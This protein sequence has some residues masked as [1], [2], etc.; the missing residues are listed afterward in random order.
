MMSF[1]S[2]IKQGFNTW[3]ASFRSS[4]RFFTISPAIELTINIPKN[5]EDKRTSHKATTSYD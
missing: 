2:Y 4:L 1:T 5:K 3:I